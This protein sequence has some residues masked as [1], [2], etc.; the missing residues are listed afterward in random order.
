DKIA[1]LHPVW[2]T[3]A[4]ALMV[5][6]I[7]VT[8]LCFSTFISPS[9]AAAYWM[10][11]ALTTITY[12]IPYLVMFPAFW[13]LRKTQPD[14]P[15]SF[16]IPGKVLP[17]VLPALGFISIAFAV[18]LLFIPPSQIDMGGYFQ[19]AGKIIGGALLAIVVA[20]WI[21]HRALKRNTRLGMVKGK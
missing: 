9:V 16:K 8:V 17:A 6:A 4:F 5:Q 3:P 20:E 2:K 14:T 11:T 18:V 13:R 7:I 1:Q 21:Y 12:F 15:R 10:L 19:Y